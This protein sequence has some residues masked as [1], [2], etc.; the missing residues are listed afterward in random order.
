MLISSA[1]YGQIAED[2]KLHF[3]VGAGVSAITYVTVLEITNDT[4]KAF[5]YSFGMSVLAGVTKELIDQRV[6]KGFDS[7]DI[8]ATSLGGVSVSFTFNLFDKQQKRRR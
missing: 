7:K 5:W 4:K 8:L 3:I 2:K 6:Y 1:S